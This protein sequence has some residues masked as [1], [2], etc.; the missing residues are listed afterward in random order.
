MPRRA[1]NLLFNN[2]PKVYRATTSPYISPHVQ[3]DLNLLL[4]HSPNGLQAS[5][6]FI[7][8][9][10]IVL[11]VKSLSMARRAGIPSQ[12]MLKRATGPYPGPTPFSINSKAEIS[13][14]IRSAGLQQV[15]TWN[16][17]VL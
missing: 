11:K 12:T 17:S 7:H 5:N 4:N 14:L 8:L 9:F 2:V 15:S 10:F 1:S 13:M 6:K 3:Q 16:Q